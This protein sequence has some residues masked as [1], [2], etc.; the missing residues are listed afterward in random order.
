LYQHDIMNIHFTSYDGRRQQDVVNP[1]TCR[2]DVMCLAEESDSEVSPRAP[3]HRLSY[4]RILGIYHVNVVY[5]GRGTLDRKPRCF[6]LLWVRPFKPFK[7]ERAWSDQQL[8]RLEFYPLEDPNTIDFL[9]PA[10]VLRACHIIPRFSLGQV[11]GRA[12]EYSRIARADE[13]WNEYFINR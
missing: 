6:D 4:Y 11:E 3:K 10:D 1:K 8:D 9:D 2:R 12:P 13:D 7:D 5:Q